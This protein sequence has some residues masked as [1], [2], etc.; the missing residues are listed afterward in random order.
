M[1]PRAAGLDAAAGAPSANSPSGSSEQRSEAGRMA[2]LLRSMRDENAALKQARDAPA[3]AAED[4][5]A[6]ATYEA[7]QAEIAKALAAGGAPPSAEVYYRR[8]LSMLQLS[9]E[10]LRLELTNVK[11]QLVLVKQQLRIAR[12]DSSRLKGEL[13]R[14]KALLASRPAAPPPPWQ[15]TCRTPPARRAAPG[16]RGSRAAS[17]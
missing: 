15:A 7:N 12:A 13:D 5:S 16:A 4:A 17:A 11:Q 14:T 6:F 2:E 3:A 8:D 10:R 1:R 9:D